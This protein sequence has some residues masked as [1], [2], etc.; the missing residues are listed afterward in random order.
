MAASVWVLR[1]LRGNHCIDPLVLED[2]QVGGFHKVDHDV[3]AEGHDGDHQSS[4]RCK[5]SWRL[6]LHLVATCSESALHKALENAKTLGGHILD[7]GLSKTVD[8]KTLAKLL[9]DL[10]HEKNPK[11]QSPNV[12]ERDEVL[13]K[14]QCAQMNHVGGHA[15]GCTHV[16]HKCIGSKEWNIFL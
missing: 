5:P 13:L 3:L 4:P 11:Y 10:F 6:L 2:A 8:V 9:F 1:Q 14:L 16:L 7:V 15:D 12:H